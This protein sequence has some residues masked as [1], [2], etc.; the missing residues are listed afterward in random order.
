MCPSRSRADRGT[1]RALPQAAAIRQTLNL[2]SWAYPV[3]GSGSHDS[4]EAARRNRGILE[5][6]VHHDQPLVSCKLLGQ[7]RCKLGP[8]LDCSHS[9][10][11]FEQRRRRLAYSRAYLHH[12]GLLRKRVEQP[13][14]GRR[15]VRGPSAFVHIGNAV[16][17][18]SHL[19]PSSHAAKLA[20]REL[21]GRQADCG[22]AHLAGRQ[23]TSGS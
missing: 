12:V 6:R 14:E 4:I 10:I 17:A 11:T 7:S 15:R 2:L 21:A 9:C 23:F 22:R 5:R 19:A 8:K 13:V 1:Q 3:I 18:Q 16:E 20:L